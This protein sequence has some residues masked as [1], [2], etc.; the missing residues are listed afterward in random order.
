MRL[1]ESAMPHGSFVARIDVVEPTGADTQV[2]ARSGDAP[3]TCVFAD[4][5]HFGAGDLIHL[6]P[7]PDRTHLFDEQSGRSLMP[8]P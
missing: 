2:Y 5:H 8:T 4:R 1:S 6:V 3:L 7:Q